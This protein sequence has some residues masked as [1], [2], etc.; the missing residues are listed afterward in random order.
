MAWPEFPPQEQLDAEAAGLSG[1]TE[2]VVARNGTD[3]VVVPVEYTLDWELRPGYYYPDELAAWHAAQNPEPTPE[4]EPTPDPV[5][6]VEPTPEPTP[7]ATGLSMDVVTFL[8]ESDPDVAQVD[9]HVHTAAM[10][11]RAYTRGRGFEGG[12][13]EEDVAAVIVSCAAR[14]YRNPTLDRSQ[15]VGPFQTAPGSFHGWSLPELAILHRYRQRA[16]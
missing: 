1:A 5:P 11:V 14:L 6:P 13:P 15:Q 12:F 7:V 2:T 8:G 3:Y 16:R 9:A 10:M 4:P